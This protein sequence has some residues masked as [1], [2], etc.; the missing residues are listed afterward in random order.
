MTVRNTDCKAFPPFLPPF[1]FYYLLLHFSFLCLF[2]SLRSL[3]P[4]P[5][6]PSPPSPRVQVFL[7]VLS[8]SH[9][10]DIIHEKGL[11]IWKGQ[12]APGD[13]PRAN[14]DGFYNIFNNTEA[15]EVTKNE[16]PDW[17]GLITELCPLYA[18]KYK[19]ISVKIFKK[20]FAV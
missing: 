5:P 2:L 11:C 15:Y 13:C 20:Q 3:P 14:D 18:R 17:Y 4:S 16:D 1:L 9:S 7:V 19:I 6:P 8:Q 12:C 10:A